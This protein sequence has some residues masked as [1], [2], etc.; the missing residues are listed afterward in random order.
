MNIDIIEPHNR[1]RIS[2]GSSGSSSSSSSSSN[3]KISSIHQQNGKLY[4]GFSNGDLSIYA[5][6]TDDKEIDDQQQQQQQAPS[7]SSKARSI[8]SLKTFNDIK[9][10]FKDNEKSGDF[11]L[12]K[13]FKNISQD[14]ASIDLIKVLP[15]V[16]QDSHKT[17]IL[18]NTPEAVRIYE[19]VGSHI[20]QIHKFEDS[21]NCSDVLY[22]E[23]DERRLLLLGIKKRF[24]VFQII[25][26]S[27]NL[28]TFTKI[29]EESLKDKVRTIDNYIEE[30]KVIIGLQ[31]DYLLIDVRQDFKISS[32]PVDET[33]VNM[34]THN[35]SFSYFGFTSSGPMT[36]TVPIE[37]ED[38]LLLVRDTQI[39]K[40]EKQSQGDSTITSSPIKLLVVPIAIFSIH[41]LYLVV[42]YNK[43][44]EVLDIQNGDLIQKFHH[45]INSNQIHT[46]M[47]GPTINL[48]AG[49]D[50]LQF[51]IT[52]FQ[53]QIE[54]FLSISGKGSSSG[55][56]KDP[57]N[58][59]KYIGLEKCISLVSKLDTS[60]SVFHQD[61]SKD[62]IK[63]KQMKLRELYTSKALM[64]FESYSKFHES[65][66]E[67]SLE[68]LV[69]FQ[70]ILEL[71]PDFLNAQKRLIAQVQDSKDVGFPNSPI[72]RITIEDLELHL[73]ISESEYDTADNASRRLAQP[74]A[75]ST[76]QIKSVSYVKAQMNVRR[77]KKA[78]NN[79]IVYLTD[80]R[81]I[82]STFRNKHSIKWKG[83]DLFPRDVYPE[84]SN[85]PIQQLDKV[86]TI[87]DT[88]LFLCYFY[89]KPMLLGPLLRLPSNNCDSKTVNQCLLSNI[90]NHTQQRNF[91]QPNF[92]KELLDFYFGRSLHEDA[93]VMLY[94]LAHDDD[95]NGE[96]SI[97]QHSND[98]DNLLDD[99]LR[100]P[101]LSIQ[102]LQKLKNDDLSL[103][104]KYSNWILD[105]SN[106]ND[107]FG[108]CKLIFMNDTY[109]C[110]SYDNSRIL[111]YFVNTRKDSGLAIGYLEWLLFESDL[112]S[113]LIKTKQ[114]SK[115]ETRL[116]NLYLK[117]L[118][119]L[120]VD[121][122]EFYQSDN[123]I[124]LFELLKSG[125]EYD[126]WAVLK[127]IPT[128][129]DKF[130]RFTI[131][132][133][134]RLGEHEKSIDV[135]FNQLNDLDGAMDYCSEIYCLPNG[136]KAG[137]GLFHKLLED[138]LIHYQDN[139]DLIARLLSLQGSKMSTLKTLACLPDSFPLHKLSKFATN[140]IGTIQES[141]HDSRISAQLYKVGAINLESKVVTLQ[142]DSYKV[143]CSFV[144]TR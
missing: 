89:C 126:P 46:S 14:G 116:C 132:I 108:N 17:I 27:R 111:N 68:W 140:Q 78:V 66:V 98:E 73:G 64:L 84:L 119:E 13:R 79:L 85:D 28:F 124:K 133:Y 30:N 115:F 70:D 50:I 34:F 3:E 143:S 45:Q 26:K 128:T 129:E 103:I 5:S 87:I 25:N 6:K 114:V 121:D 136:I 12:V 130:L 4:V 38:K 2:N 33:N 72:K 15:M 127:N 71:F 82:L 142:N 110:E 42:I 120:E 135:L 61:P 58:D 8:R 99:Y 22:L 117:Q 37:H 90:H 56:I 101:A 80:Q 63:A 29:H 125:K 55:N 67:I 91:K 107:K 112:I 40:L 113:K 36:W 20:N 134:K 62:P 35:T 7:S 18:T 10:L 96:S 122:Y 86:A 43:K 52:S 48:A 49:S 11:T 102:Y 123:Y 81:R 19:I 32:L 93:L 51:N 92:I 69:S 41:P 118:K 47:E 23:S 77:F 95:N 74:P 137:E 104:F 53:R 138:L 97:A 106:Q 100:G 105:E 131:F 109:E 75:S 21:K 1:I 54:Q 59:L 9:G 39:V 141:L 144:N 88:S 139:V 65:L 60:N 83:I 44:L 76:S 31:N 16:Q 94:K 24:V 57:H